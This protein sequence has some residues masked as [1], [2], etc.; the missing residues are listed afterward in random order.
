MKVKFGSSYVDD[1][2][3]LIIVPEDDGKINV[4]WFLYEIIALSIPIQHTHAPGEC[5]EDMMKILKEHSSQN[6]ND[7]SEVVENGNEMDPRWN[8]LKKLLNNN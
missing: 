8:E 7:D 1:G 5:N 6:L 3:D 2:D 4:A